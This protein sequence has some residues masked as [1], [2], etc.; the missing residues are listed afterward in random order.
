LFKKISIAYAVL[1][2]PNKRRQYDLSGPSGAIVD[3]EGFDLSEMGGV[4]TT[5]PRQTSSP[6]SGRVFG[7]LFS[8]LG[9]PIPTQI[10]PKVL[11]QARSL[12][13]GTPCD[14]KYSVLEE[15]VQV[16]GSI[17]K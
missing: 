16:D 13:E 8:K 9:V 7:A 3:F 11:A 15:G 14:A 17:G 2:D 6:N 5:H 10:T 12:C 4:V 1:S